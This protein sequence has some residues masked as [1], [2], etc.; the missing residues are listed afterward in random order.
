MKKKGIILLIIGLGVLAAVFFLRDTTDTAEVK[1]EQEAS[2]EEATEEVLNEDNDLFG[3]EV[4][5]GDIEE[6]PLALDTTKAEKL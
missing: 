1:K 6:A 2:I 3:D 5:F 4:D